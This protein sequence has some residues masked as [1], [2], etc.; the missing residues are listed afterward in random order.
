MW[1]AK[2]VFDGRKAA[3][4][5]RTLKY[6]VSLTGFPLFYSYEKRE[7]LVNISGIIVGEKRNKKRFIED[8]RNSG[9]LLNLEL[10][11]DFFLGTI[12]EPET[13][14]TIYNYK[15]I[16]IEPTIIDEKGN[17][18]ITVASFDKKNIEKL[19][20]TLEKFNKT[21][22]KYIQQR[23][24]KSISIVREN[25]ELTEKQKKAMM[26]AI[27]NG[28]YEYPRKTSIEKLAEISKISFST[29]HA[30]L[31]KAEYKLLPFY[32]ES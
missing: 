5:S 27:K 13:T 24:V 1:V 9:R 15:I 22:I 6:G 7:V 3:I 12:R 14:K 18:T 25:P 8:W 19:I 16:H 4:G 21:E 28:Y 11:Q 26:L 17:E 10:S 20:K 23:K 31:R 30:H 32:F 29:F 2:I